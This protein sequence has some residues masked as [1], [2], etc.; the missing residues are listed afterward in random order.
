VVDYFAPRTG[1]DVRARESVEGVL[2]NVV[3][4]QT[5]ICGERLESID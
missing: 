2:V 3:A 4:A 1:R 5:V